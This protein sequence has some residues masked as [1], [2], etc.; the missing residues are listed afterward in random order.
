VAP[1]AKRSA[2]HWPESRWIEVARTLCAKGHRVVLLGTGAE[3]ELCRRI[4]DSAGPSAASLA[5]NTKLNELPAV[6]RRAI[7]AV[8]V[9]SG[10][11]HVASAVGTPCVSLFSAREHKGKWHPQGHHTVIEKRIACHTCLLDRCP[12]DNLCMREI[13]ASE[14]IAA[15][16]ER[17]LRNRSVDLLISRR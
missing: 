4:A 14:V 6:L 16:E 11:Q 9:D 1:G 3:A 15:C 7:F 17:A 10:I 5:G 8:C 12:R 13:S 2:N